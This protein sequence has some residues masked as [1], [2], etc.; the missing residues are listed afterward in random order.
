MVPEGLQG[1]RGWVGLA[2]LGE[3]SQLMTSPSRGREKSKACIWHSG[4]SEGYPR[5][6]RWS[7]LTRGANRELRPLRKRG[8]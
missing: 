4:C 1:H 2:W 3:E 5:D 8:E 7:H 6:L